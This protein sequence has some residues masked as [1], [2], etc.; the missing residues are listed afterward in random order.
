VP[1]VA[2]TSSATDIRERLEAIGL[3]YTPV[4][5]S[6]LNTEECPIPEDELPA[7]Q[8]LTRKS[9]NHVWSN[10]DRRVVVRTWDITLYVSEICDPD[11]AVDIRAA[12]E[13]AEVYVDT[14]ADMLAPTYPNLRLS[15]DNGLPGIFRVSAPLDNGPAFRDWGGK[16]YAIVHTPL[17]V[18]YYRPQ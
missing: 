2:G 5:N 3:A 7:L 11:S 14:I 17:T 8:V 18:E 1:Q 9:T 10:R 12:Y 13:D 16:T 4:I 15:G 6:V